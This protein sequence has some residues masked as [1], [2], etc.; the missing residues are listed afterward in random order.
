MQTKHR[1]DGNNYFIDAESATELARLINQDRLL[2]EN[3][4]GLFPEFQDI[5]SM[6]DIRYCLWPWSVGT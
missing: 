2:T 4:G 3:M 5:S 1:S 6:H